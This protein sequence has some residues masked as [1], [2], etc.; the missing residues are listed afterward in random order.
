MRLALL[1]ALMGILTAI[2]GAIGSPCAAAAEFPFTGYVA[3]D[4]AEVAAGAGRRFYVTDHLPLGAEVEVY[5]EDDAGWL[6]IRPPAGSFSWIPAEHVE[7][8]AGDVGK[9]REPTESWIGTS[10][11][12]VK[13]H[14]SQVSLK[15][16]ELVQILAEKK[17]GEGASQ[18]H[19]LKIAPPAGEFRFVHSRDISREPVASPPGSGEEVVVEEDGAA[20]GEA[21]AGEAE[22]HEPIRQPRRFRPSEGAIAL[23]DIDEVRSR[24]AAMRE[25]LAGL[26]SRGPFAPQAGPR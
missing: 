24:L 14:A 23:R 21:A 22:Q 4:A 6:A 2:D 19:W 11:E 1:A 10:V 18:E 9:V 8:L 7:R 20:A 13:E 15:A 16:G 26:A 3:T 17:V 12:Q 25:D 5:R